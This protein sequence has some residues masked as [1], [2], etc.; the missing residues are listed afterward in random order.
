MTLILT[1]DNCTAIPT[2]C[3]AGI[4]TG[5]KLPKG[6]GVW[7]IENELK[8]ANLY[9]YLQARFG[10]PNGL[11][12]IF[13]NDDS[14]NL[15]H[16]EWA[17][18]HKN[19]LILIMG[20][21]MRS[22]VHLLGDWDFKNLSRDQFIEYIKGDFGNYGK[23]MS[24]FRQERLEHWDIFVNPYHDIHSA[25]KQMISDI[26]A[27]NI[28]PSKDELPNPT[29]VSEYAR[30]GE[31]WSAL[32]EKYNR[33]IGLAM[34][35]RSLTPVLAE[36]FINLL[37]YLLC[38]EDIKSNKRLYD[39]FVRQNIDVKVQSLHINCQGFKKP[40]DW[41]SQPCADYNSIVN[42]RNDLLHG[43]VVPSKQIFQD[44]H[45][46]GKVPIFEEYKSIWQQSVGVSITSSGLRVVR[47]CVNVIHKFED[48]VLS[49]LVDG[50]EAQVR[51][52]MSKRDLGLNRSNG[53][54]GVLLP[55]HL[56]DFGMSVI[57][58]GGQ[59]ADVLEPLTRP[60]DP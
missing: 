7:R 17:L 32:M 15:I 12:N 28:D 16:W 59:Q 45:F 30:F 34:G 4:M 47:D 9:C 20:L 1:L 31:N 39:N 35:I 19:G 58:K 25:I 29:V 26:D 53:R 52:I 41:S 56:V 33:A 5:G 43:N 40:V 6:G 10:D 42:D 27:L 36:S 3:I 24:K 51:H 2:K 38:R 8:P 11:Q 18:A 60:G 46:R 50:L 55:D 49:C 14:D 37:A 23:Q 44:I 13:R 54:I 22:E 57:Q 48:Y 21:N